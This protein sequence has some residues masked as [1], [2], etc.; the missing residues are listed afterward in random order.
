MMV[1]YLVLLAGGV[2]TIAALLYVLRRIFDRPPAPAPQMS[3][4]AREKLNVT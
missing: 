3:S 2:L 4:V 1:S